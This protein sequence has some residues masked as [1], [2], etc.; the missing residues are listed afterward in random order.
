MTD[1]LP[2]I[3]PSFRRRRG[4]KVL[5][6]LQVLVLT[7][8]V[9][10]RGMRAQTPDSLALPPDTSPRLAGSP[11]RLPD[12]TKANPFSDFETHFL[13]NGL[14]VW[15]KHWPDAPNV[16][17]SVGVPYGWDS[18]PRGKEELAHLTEHMLFSDHDGQTE[19]E[20][21][22]AI[23]EIGGRRNGFTTPDH[24][25]YYVTVSK[26]HGAFAIEWLSRVMSPHSMDADLVERNRQPVAL[27]INTRPREFFEQVW[28]LLNPSWLL[29]PDFWQ[30]EFGMETRSGRQY[31]RWASLQSITP[32]DIADFY[33]RYYVPGAMTLT[34]IGDLNRSEVLEISERTFGSFPRR[35]VP[36]TDVDVED[37]DRRRATSYWGF[38]PNVQ[39]SARYKFFNTGA[40]DDLMVLFVRDLLRLRLNDRLR[41]GEQKAVY[42]LQVTTTRRGPGGFLQIRG[43]IDEDEYDFAE[44]IIQEEIAAFRGG[45]LQPD[46]FEVDRTALVER[47]RGENLTA[48]ALNFWVLRNFYDPSKH[49]DFPDLISFFEGVTQEEMASFATRSLVPEREVNTLRRV[50]PVSQGV[51]ATA[52]LLLVFLTLRLVAWTLTRPVTMREIQ[53]VARFRMPI[54]L[55]IVA[56]ALIGGAGLI[57]TRLIVFVGQSVALAFLVTVDDYRIQMTGYALM[58]ATAVVLSILYL[59]RFPRKLLVFPDH[60]RINSLAYR[61]RVFGPDDI[62][63]ISTRRF[64]QVWFRKDL[65]RCVPLT[66]GLAGPGIYLRPTNGRAYF[67]RTRNSRELIDVLGAWRGEPVSPAKPKPAGQRQDAV[68]TT[69]VSVARAPLPEDEGKGKGEGEGEGEGEGKGEGKGEEVDYDGIGLTDEELE[70]L[71]GDTHSPDPDDGGV[72]G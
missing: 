31:D 64:H 13:S 20:I 19:Q 55:Q 32:E 61:S 67:F 56:A 23:E 69:S 58:L 8:L 70:E 34:V 12:E 3:G 36:P 6:A 21:K 5:Q 72:A 14:K 33:D 66:L 11:T 59:S 53:Y 39:Y 44:A 4:R 50:Q 62:E 41:Y 49:V 26:E 35:P 28:A 60:L 47:L 7:G 71:L 10:P 51:L 65:F 63:E 1:I 45:T 18:D 27:E 48:Q 9:V 15:F 22:D 52:V 68:N 54:L 17:V 25:W 2:G 43:S 57:L 30:R 38:S 37:P 40:E 29:P 16:S 24:T 42:G 46:E